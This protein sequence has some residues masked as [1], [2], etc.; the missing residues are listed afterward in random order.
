MFGVVKRSSEK[1][2][3]LSKREEETG[4]TAKEERSHPDH[5]GPGREKGGDRKNKKV[6]FQSLRG[7]RVGEK[8]LSFSP[9]KK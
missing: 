1:W 7:K 5:P 8:D 2:W 4:S 3:C 6:L 9:T